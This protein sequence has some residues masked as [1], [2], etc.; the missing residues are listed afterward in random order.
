MSRRYGFTLI[1]LMIVIAI[2]SIIVA[3]AIPNI[4]AARMAGNE[5][6]AIGALR[7]ITSAE[8]IFNEGDKEQDGNLDYAMLSELSNTTL[9]DSVLGTGTKAGFLFS[10][11]YSFTSS[12]Y[13]WF[14]M[15]NPSL[16]T[17][18]GERYFSVNMG[19]SIFYTSSTSLSMDTSSCLLPN[20]HVIPTGK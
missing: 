1:E 2:I 15:A 18:T 5:T 14:G 13:L 19:G 8:N 17:L 9:V 16:P 6:N 7:T 20:N 11:G 4:M 10:V 12:E 3:I